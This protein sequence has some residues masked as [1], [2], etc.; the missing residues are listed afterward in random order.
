MS[1]VANPYVPDGDITFVDTLLRLMNLSN[2]DIYVTG[3]NSRM[4]SSDILTEFRGRG[5]EIRL[6]TLSYAEFKWACPKSCKT[7]WKDY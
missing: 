5:D 6:Y 4:L 7:P 1:T 3:S 2:V